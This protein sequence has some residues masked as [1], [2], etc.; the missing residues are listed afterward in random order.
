[1]VVRIVGRPDPLVADAAPVKALYVE[2]AQEEL[3]AWWEKFP[4]PNAR[5]RACRFCK[6]M[7]TVACSADEHARCLNFTKEKVDA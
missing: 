4:S 6:D 7:V 3:E 1:M 2:A 5:R